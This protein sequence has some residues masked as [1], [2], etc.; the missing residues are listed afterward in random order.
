M[1]HEE[2]KQEAKDALNKLFSDPSIPRNVKEELL[3]ELVN[4]I[5][6]MKRMLWDS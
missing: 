3:D 6:M 2:R 1:I 5:R 4:D